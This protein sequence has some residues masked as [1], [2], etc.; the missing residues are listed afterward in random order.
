[1]TTDFI[2]QWRP[3]DLF[4]IREP[5]ANGVPEPR[6]YEGLGNEIPDP[7]SLHRHIPSGNV[8]LTIIYTVTAVYEETN[9]TFIRFDNKDEDFFGRREAEHVINIEG[10]TREALWIQEMVNLVEGPS[11]SLWIMARHLEI[12]YCRKV[13]I[14]PMTPRRSIIPTGSQH[15]PEPAPEPAQDYRTTPDYNTGMDRMRSR[16]R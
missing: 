7:R 14:V 13:R 2:E 1:M 11:E 5:T 9:W 15:Y 8:D 6:F 12:P 3:G 4:V 10:E 16:S